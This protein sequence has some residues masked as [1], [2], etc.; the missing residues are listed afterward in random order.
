MDQAVPTP[1][2]GG[3]AMTALPIAL[4][5]AVARAVRRAYEQPPRAYH[6]FGH[7]LDVLGHFERVPDWHGASSVALAIL[8]HDAIYVA[9]QPDNEA[10]SAELAATL[11]V[12]TAHAPLIPRVQQLILLTA[13]HGSLEPSEVDH[14]AALFLDCD[15]AI[16]GALPDAYDAYERAIAEEYAAISPI[17]YRAGRARF[18]HKLLAKPRI[19]LSDFF[20]AERETQARANLKRALERLT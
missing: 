5:D 16:L 17:A 14:D 12:K 20:A 8:F 15:M 4:P 9:G 10:R 6:N 7:V 18:I 19:Y 2:T 11:L 13:R 1:K 3:P